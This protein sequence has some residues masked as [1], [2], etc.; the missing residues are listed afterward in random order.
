MLGISKRG[1]HYL[2]S[3]LIHGARA[4]LWAMARRGEQPNAWDGSNSGGAPMSRRSR[5]PTRTHEC[6][7]PYSEAAKLIERRPLP[8]ALSRLRVERKAS[9]EESSVR[10]EYRV[11]VPM[12]QVVPSRSAR[13][14]SR[15]ARNAPANAAL[16]GGRALRLLG[17]YAVAFATAAL[18]SHSIRAGNSV[19][20]L[21]TS[22][23]LRRPYW[24]AEWRTG[25]TGTF[26]TCRKFRAQI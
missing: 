19:Y 7:G 14:P 2:R 13:P 9:E 12:S 18:R 6:C 3:L 5:W 22:L 15:Y 25:R 10:S 24:R 26:Q 8:L 23:R 21:D 17:D 11:Q 1:D 4:A 16:D 20:R